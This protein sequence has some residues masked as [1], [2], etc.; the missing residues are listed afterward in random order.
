VRRLRKSISH[1]VLGT[2]EILNIT[3]VKLLEEIEPT[4]MFSL[5]LLLGL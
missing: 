3:K 5:R 1:R 2:W 4:Q